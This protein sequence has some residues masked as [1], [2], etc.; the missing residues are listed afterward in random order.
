MLQRPGA[1]GSVF[2]WSIS[3]LIH[4]LAVGWVWHAWPLPGADM[5]TGPVR[6]IEVRLIPVD[7]K[8]PPLPPAPD[9][10]V[11]ESTPVLTPAPVRPSL[12]PDRRERV[13]PGKPATIMPDWSDDSISAGDSGTNAVAP[14]VDL[15]AARATARLIARES[16]NGLVALPEHKLMIDLN[17]DRHVIDPIE[18]AR[19]VDCQKAHAGSIN[20]LANV[21]L[22]AADLAKNALDDSGCKW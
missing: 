4:A 9:V 11:P 20:L 12:R 7:P 16:G 17:A 1:R 8:V 10:A 18:R 22:L 13:A 6:R 15:A 2:G 19:R 21:V 5:D 14:T 3:L